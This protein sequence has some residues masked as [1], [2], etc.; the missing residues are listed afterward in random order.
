LASFCRF[1]DADEQAPTRTESTSVNG[2]HSGPQV[3]GTAERL[4]RDYVKKIF[5]VPYALPPMVPE[6]LDI[7]LKSIYAEATLDQAQLK[8][9]QQRV[10]PH[11]GYVAVERRVNPREVKRF[12]NA[13]T[14]QTLVRTELDRDTVLSVQTLAFR[15]EWETLYD[16]LL[17]EPVLFVD[18]LR[19]YRGG[20]DTALEDL[21]PELGS[22]P[23]D[24]TSYLRSPTAEPLV[25]HESLEPYLSSLRST[26]SIHGWVLDAYGPAGRLRREVRKVRD[27]TRIGQRD[28]QTLATTVSETVPTLSS[29][30]ISQAGPD[31]ARRLTKLV[32]RARQLGQELSNAGL[33]EQVNNWDDVL[34]PLVNELSDIA[35][36]LYRE[37]QILRRPT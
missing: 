3:A 29:L 20:H 28:A 23:P 35:E 33:S 2:N 26:S 19:R 8:D 17:A 24:L 1:A 32:E 7:L 9:L 34:H 31:S 22:L 13:Y 16:V 30:L 25:R 14:L 36:R 6:Q 21:S 15:Y 11:L 12:I 18:A 5:Q 10:R 37:L 27:T 4:S